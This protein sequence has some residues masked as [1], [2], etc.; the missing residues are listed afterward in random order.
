MHRASFRRVVSF[1]LIGGAVFA[2][3]C[4]SG[5]QADRE[6]AQML[7]MQQQLQHVQSEN[8]AMQKERNE[9]QSKAQQ[10]EQAQKHTGQEL[11]RARQTA[12]AQSK[13]LEDTRTELAAKTEALGAAQTQIENLQKDLAQ[14][15]EAL[16]RAAAEKR[17]LDAELSHATT[18]LTLNTARADLCETRHDGLMKFST[19]L[20]D[21]Y[22]RERLRLCEPI[23]GIWK[24]KS[25]TQ[26]QQMREEL[27]GYRLDIPPPPVPAAAATTASPEID[28]KGISSTQ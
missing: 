11:A 8:A 15:D 20:I 2:W 3:T 24:V 6:R 19:A 17:R 9:L 7:Q 26:V 23:T 28:T 13:E 21:R 4:A 27:Y 16:Q 1:V 18:R 22:D 25:E 14:R 5:Q 12:A 10:A